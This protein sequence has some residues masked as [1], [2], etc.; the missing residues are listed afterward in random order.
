MKASVILAAVILIGLKTTNGEHVKECSK[1]CLCTV[2]HIAICTGRNLNFI[3]KIPND[4]T[5]FNMTETNLSYI[6]EFGFANITGNIIKKLVLEKNRIEFI[7]K[8]ALRKFTFLKTLHISYEIRLDI[9]ILKMAL[10]NIAKNHLRYINLLY[11]KWSILPN[12][13]F[14]NFTSSKIRKIW[15]A[16]IDH[17]FV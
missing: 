12:D 10:T 4:V 16:G 3:P 6:G 9:N 2:D 1:F 5:V 13:I 11:N 17:H 8:F 15:L 7:H 14:A